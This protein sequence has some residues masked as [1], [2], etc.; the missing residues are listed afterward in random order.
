VTDS[1]THA[2]RAAQHDDDARTPLELIAAYRRGP[3]VLRETVNGLKQEHLR[4]R[5]IPGK[6]SALEVLAHVADCEQFLADRMKRTAALERPLLVGVDGALYLEALG[7]QDRDPELDLSLVEI[8]RAQMA[9]DLE[10]LPVK[11][12]TREAIHTETGLV[13]LRGLLL[14]SIRHLEHHT[15]A[16]RDK[17]LALGL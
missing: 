12:W 11:A 6:M 1:D 9:A 13:T 8:T 14:H 10:R 17:R 2:V 3:I 5:P 7:Y 16:I 15:Q 4:A